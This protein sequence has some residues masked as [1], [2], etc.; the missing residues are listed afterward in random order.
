MNNINKDN[1]SKGNLG[2]GISI[3]I[4][5]SIIEIGILVS[6]PTVSSYLV[7]L[8]LLFYLGFIV[9]F[10]KNGK[11]FTAIGMLIIFGFALFL[12]AACFG[13]FLSNN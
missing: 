6:F 5:F 2:I 9:Y 13:L 4:I 12:T 1:Q 11:K 10:F 8:L 3:G 7:W